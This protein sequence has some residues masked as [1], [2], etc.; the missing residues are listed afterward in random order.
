MTG[1]LPVMALEVIRYTAPQRGETVVDATLGLGGH[2]ALLGTAIGPEGTLVG[3]DWDAELL[4]RA[5]ERLAELVCRK[6]FIHSDFRKLPAV[7]GQ[8]GIRHA[9]V[10]TADLGVCSAHLDRAER[11]FSFQQ[12]GPLDMRMDRSQVGRT[13]EH[14]LRSTSEAELERI[15][16]EYGEERHARAI[17][18]AILVRVRQGRM[19]ST[20][21]LVAAVSDAVPPHARDRRIHFATRTFQAIRCAVTGELVGLQDAVEQAIGLLSPGGRIAV[22]AYHSLED[23]QIKRAFARLSGKCICERGV[24][25]CRCGKVQLVE[26]LTPKPVRPTA[27]E[28]RTNPRARSAKLRVARRI[29]G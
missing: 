27:E 23:R 13:A 6:H 4:E 26:V 18:R 15:L 8:L 25:E 9:D 3:L 5:K 17:A 20:G 1:H 29:S 28:I 19:R 12:E 24:P 22:L 2:A 11:G 16:K 10:I 7:L 14:L 21:D